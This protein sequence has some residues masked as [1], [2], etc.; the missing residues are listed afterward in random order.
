MSGLPIADFIYAYRLNRSVVFGDVTHIL[1][2]K[3][4]ESDDNADEIND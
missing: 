3:V 2:E 4:Q 1:L